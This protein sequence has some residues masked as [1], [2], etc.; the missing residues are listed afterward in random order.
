MME[1]ISAVIITFNEE[2]KLARCIE[3]VKPVADE[4]I[5]LD[6]FSTDDTV[7]IALKS[8]A[9]VHQQTFHGYK[10]QKNAA[11]QFATHD[12]VLSIDADETLSVEL[13][14]SIL[15]SKEK[16]ACRAYTMNR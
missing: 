5:V 6:S 12:Y 4:I 16:F 14:H 13:I 2:R 10:E 7:K 3:S 11:L 9:I 1:K 15:I 8:G